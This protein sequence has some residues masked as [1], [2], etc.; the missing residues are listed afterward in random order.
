MNAIQFLST[1]S[2]VE[3]LGWTLVHFLWQGALIAA[4]YALARVWFGRT[5]TAGFRYLLSCTALLAMVIAPIATFAFLGTDTSPDSIATAIGSVGSSS[6]TSDPYWQV[7]MTTGTFPAWYN[8]ATA[9]IVLAWFAGAMAF[10]ARL[11]GSWFA[12]SRIQSMLIRPAPA[13]WQRDLDRLRTR[14]RLSRPVRLLV[15]AAVQVPTVA[16][17]LRPVVLVPVGVLTGL[18]PDLVE[19]L[20]VHEL[21]HVRR[22]DYLVNVLQGIAETMLFYHPAVWWV[23]GQIRE[24]RELCCDDIA[25]AACGDTLTYVRALAELESCR[26]AH[27][28]PALAANGG[29]LAARIARLLGA[30]TSTNSSSPGSA[31]IAMALI[32]IATACL[33]LGQSTANPANSPA[34][35]AFEVASVKQNTSGATRTSSAILQGGRFTA[36]NNTVR[37]LILNAYGIWLSPSLLSGGPGWIDSDAWDIDARA[38][39]NAIP[40]NVAG[41]PLWDKTRLMLRTLLAD[42][43][44]LSM[45]QDTKEM[46]IYELVVAKNGPKLKSVK[47]DCAA[48]IN[49]CH[50]FSGNPRRLTGSGVDMWD[51]ALELTSFSDRLVKDKTGIQGLFDILLQWNPFA[52][53]PEPADYVAAAPAG[54][55]REGPMADLAS[56]PNVFDALEQ[57]VGLKLQAQ[58]APVEVYV[59]DHVER[60]SEN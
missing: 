14:L 36:T 18:P 53:R 20:L 8:S 26:P 41:K 17:W 19:A 38:E 48:G 7:P 23:S 25:V 47:P 49:A 31:M 54:A 37:A 34:P 39:A 50:G 60:P 9:W 46:S 11:A 29:V 10:W 3:R 28:S 55:G 51:L 59:I 40:S 33:A 57:Q 58:K 4:L 15:S 2:W 22:H 35:L 12:A 21:A 27:L 56:L 32:A 1:Q 30:S 44:K 42:R 13:R 5:R 24:E 43:F 52:G 6:V 16:G 45:H